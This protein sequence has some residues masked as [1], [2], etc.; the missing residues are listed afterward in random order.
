[1]YHEAMAVASSPCMKEI[2]CLHDHRW[3]NTILT[4]S[5]VYKTQLPIATVIL[6]TLYPRLHLVRVDLNAESQDCFQLLYHYA[7]TLH[8]HQVDLC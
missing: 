8:L 5:A 2:E 6:Y 4:L 1:M 3:G 7:F